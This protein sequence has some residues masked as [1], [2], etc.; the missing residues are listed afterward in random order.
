MRA[1]Q[2]A[3]RLEDEQGAFRPWQV[4]SDPRLMINLPPRAG[5]SVFDLA[6]IDSL[7]K[8]SSMAMVWFDE[9][10]ETYDPRLLLCKAGLAQ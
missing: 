9:C 4:H 8:G 2:E 10:A 5:K 6:Y 7:I 1:E 3:R